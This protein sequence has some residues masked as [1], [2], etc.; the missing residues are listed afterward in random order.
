MFPTTAD[1]VS[2]NT[3]AHVN[4]RI[5][6]ETR[7]QAERIAARGPLA[8]RRRLRELDREWDIERTLEANAATLSAAG[9]ALALGVD[10]RFA[11]IPLVVGGFLLQHALQGW[12]PPL[13]LFRRLGV[14][15]QSE[16]DA[17]RYALMA[18]RGDF[19]GVDEGPSAARAARALDTTK[20]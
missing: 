14:R 10:R 6:R 2:E 19:R 3:A 4:E 16:I 12:C 7:W 20:S 9:A 18:L 15:T 13:P 5:R 8:V 1:R 11:A 17:E